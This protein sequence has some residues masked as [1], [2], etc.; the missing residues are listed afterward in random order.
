M[1]YICVMDK[2]NIILSFFVAIV[3]LLMMISP[4]TFISMVVIILGVAVIIDGLFIMITTRN[5]ILDPQYRLMMTIRGIL[6]IVTG[7]MAIFLPLFVAKIIYS[8][9]SYVLAIYLLISAALE[10]YGISKLHRNGIMI[11]QSVI[12]TL[13]SVVLAVILFIIPAKTAGS[14]IVRI[15]GTVLL[16]IGII[17]GIIQWKNRPLTVTPDSVTP[18]DDLKNSSENSAGENSGK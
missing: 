18:E 15:L 11:R 10:C 5:L 7:I 16:L 6:S 3:G 12:E 14:I 2:N 8:I 17:W 1:T 9:M 13:V 4:E